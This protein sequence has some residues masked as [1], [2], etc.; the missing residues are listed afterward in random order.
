MDRATLLKETLAVITDREK[1][2][3]DP[4]LH[5]AKVGRVWSE[6]AGIDI[7]GRKACL[8]MAALKILRDCEVEDNVNIVDMDGYGA[9]AVEVG[10]PA[11]PKEVKAAPVVERPKRSYRRGK[12]RAERMGVSSRI[13]AA[14][15]EVLNS[16]PNKALRTSDLL[17]M[18]YT[19]LRI[20]ETKTMAKYTRSTLYSRMHGALIGAVNGRAMRRFMQNGDS[21]YILRSF[22][23]QL[24]KEPPAASGNLE[25]RESLTA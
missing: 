18:T 1:R 15:K 13:R 10:T 6:I 7:P 5:W 22:D 20:H 11:P 21:W 3:G 24:A 19:W 17:S 4:K 23:E 16:V 9:I 12:P 8:M 25:A 2:Y 14:F